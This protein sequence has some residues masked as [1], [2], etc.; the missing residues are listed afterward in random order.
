[1]NFL[2]SGFTMMHVVGAR[3]DNV[4][5]SADVILHRK[6]GHPPAT[7]RRGTAD[8]AYHVPVIIC[9]KQVRDEAAA[10]RRPVPLTS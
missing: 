5:M 10:V 7:L 4:S 1:M 6:G 9:D 2:F 3:A 8:A